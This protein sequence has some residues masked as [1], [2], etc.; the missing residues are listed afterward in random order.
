MNCG[1]V[2]QMFNYENMEIVRV[3]VPIIKSLY[4]GAII[5]HSTAM[6]SESGQQL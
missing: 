5:G 6:L 2:E 4:Y 1:G 3:I